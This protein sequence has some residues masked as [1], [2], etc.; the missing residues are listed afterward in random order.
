MREIII[1][2]IGLL[3]VYGGFEFWRAHRMGKQ[4][5]EKP[6]AQSDSLQP[7]GP[8]PSSAS[9]SAGTQTRLPDRG[10]VES[11]DD[12]DDDDLIVFDPSGHLSSGRT[13]VSGERSG[14][15]GTE[16]SPKGEAAFQLELEVRQ[17]RR[18]IA[19]LRAELTEQRHEMQRMQ[20]DFVA[21]REHLE[22][23]LAGQGIS[24][25][26]NEALVYARRGLQAEEIAEQC[27]ISLAEAELVH[28]LGN[29]GEGNRR[30]GG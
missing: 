20:S 11:D 26:Y 7:S 5:P 29:S 14:G 21:A 6:S 2:L 13:A 27:G 17:L 25:E 1:I 16:G 3:A 24:P 10:G 4:L 23:S 8:T 15:A 22:T 18:D 30:E 9:P 12:D 19:Q 28:A